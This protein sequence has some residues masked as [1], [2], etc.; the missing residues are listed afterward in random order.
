MAHFEVEV[1]SLLGARD[2]AEALKKRMLALDPT[3]VVA[4]K[5]SQ[6]NHYFEGGDI[7]DL[8][9]NTADLFDEVQ[10]AK[11]AKIVEKGNNVSVRTRDK[12]GTVLLV[13]KASM[14]D[15]TS[16][17]TVSRMEFEEVVSVSLEELDQLVLNSGYQYQAKWSRDRE[18]IACKDIIVCIDRNAGYG[19]LAEFEKI[20][21]DETLLTEARAEID[22]LMTALE[23]TE[24]PQDRL[25]RM[26]DFYNRNWSDYYGTDNTFIIE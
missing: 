7:N 25:T 11:F 18:E 10:R 19:Y 16:E 13:V 24:L 6:L 14:D 8:F 12:D 20:V 3:A 4:N 15:G 5:N 26:F 17:N 23:V 1:K 9:E 2:V 21:E 22:A